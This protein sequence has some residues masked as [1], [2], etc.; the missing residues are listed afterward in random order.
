MLNHQLKVRFWYELLIKCFAHLFSYQKGELQV[1]I[2]DKLIHDDVATFSSLYR[3]SQ[4]IGKF[5]L[6]GNS[7]Q[8]VCLSVSLQYHYSADVFWTNFVL[9]KLLVILDKSP[10]LVVVVTKTENK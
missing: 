10:C 6:E 2:N 5:R 8:Y 3:G 9:V 1:E 4:F 7:C